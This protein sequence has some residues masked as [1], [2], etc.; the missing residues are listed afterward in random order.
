MYCALQLSVLGIETFG[1]S[2]EVYGIPGVETL[3]GHKN[4]NSSMRPAITGMSSTIRLL[5]LPSN[6]L[7]VHHCPFRRY[8][9]HLLTVHHKQV[10]PK[11]SA[12]PTESSPFRL[13]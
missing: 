1:S 5:W 7:P 8:L 12:V 9:L 6:F 10:D 11:G 13:M 4:I 3:Y 2:A